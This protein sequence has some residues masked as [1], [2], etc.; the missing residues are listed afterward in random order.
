[1]CLGLRGEG[2]AVDISDSD[3]YQ[4]RKSTVFTCSDVQQIDQIGHSYSELPSPNT[5]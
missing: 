4:V 1:M 2:T 3:W 5:T